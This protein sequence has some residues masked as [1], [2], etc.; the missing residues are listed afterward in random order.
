[1]EGIFGLPVLWYWS[2]TTLKQKY[3]CFIGALSGRTTIMKPSDLLH[4]SLWHL[5][6]KLKYFEQARIYARG[7]EH[8]LIAWGKRYARRSGSNSEAKYNQM[9]GLRSAALLLSMGKFLCIS[10]FYRNALPGEHSHLMSSLNRLTHNVQMPDLWFR[11]YCA[12]DKCENKIL[13]P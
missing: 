3:Q 2:Y 4:S 12:T 6:L 7:S 5:F 13:T 11:G 9:L 1:M 8:D 10:T